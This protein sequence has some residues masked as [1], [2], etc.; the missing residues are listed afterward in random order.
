MKKYINAIKQVDSTD[1]ALTSNLVQSGLVHVNDNLRILMEEFHSITTQP[2]IKTVTVTT[3]EKQIEPQLLQPKSIEQQVTK[4]VIQQPQQ[5]TNPIPVENGNEIML[6]FDSTDELLLVK[7][8]PEVMEAQ[9][10]TLIPDLLEDSPP[11]PGK[12]RRLEGLTYEQK[13]YRK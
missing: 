10:V 6:T 7:E 1:Q 12:K 2:Q 4:H 13:A 11:P 3:K 8:E 9:D 5:I